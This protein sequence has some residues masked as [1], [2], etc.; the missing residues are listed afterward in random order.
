MWC[1]TISIILVMYRCAVVQDN[2]YNPG[3]VSFWLANSSELLHFLKQDRQL[4]PSTLSAQDLLAD[5]V[6]LAFGFL[7]DCVEKELA[8]TMPVFLSTA[9]DDVSDSEIEGTHP[10]IINLE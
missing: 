1:R 10:P 4:S 6:Q 8:Q 9:R 3:N 7:V 2:Q 5:V